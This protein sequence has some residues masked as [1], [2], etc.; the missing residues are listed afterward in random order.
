VIAIAGADLCLWR[1]NIQ[2]PM[3]PS[4]YLGRDPTGAVNPS[5][6]RLSN[7]R[8]P[9]PLPKTPF[10]VGTARSAEA[11]LEVSAFLDKTVHQAL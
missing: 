5:F 4:T 3:T 7:A 9:A 8:T 1:F 10:V 6:S 2:D 11:V